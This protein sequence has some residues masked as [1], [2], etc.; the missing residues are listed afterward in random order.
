M[1]NYEGMA[2][3]CVVYKQRDNVLSSFS[4]NSEIILCMFS[5]CYAQSTLTFL[6][7]FFRYARASVR[8]GSYAPELTCC[9][10]TYY[11]AERYRCEKLISTT[12]SF[13]LAN[14]TAVAKT[15]EFL[16][17]SSKE[18]IKW[19]SSEQIVINAEEDVF[20]IILIWINGDKLERKKYFPQLFRQVRL[21]HVSPDYLCSH[22]MTNCFVRDD[23][24]CLNL[25]KGTL[26]VI[27]G[28][29]NYTF[30]FKPRK[31]PHTPVV[32]T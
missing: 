32:V 22:I 4:V 20:K 8:T 31:S 15:G 27:D 25:V 9:I 6:R 28:K 23:K 5:F 24:F 17:M 29:V 3:Y 7:H 30:S 21:P 16:N 10:S 13:M 26:K 14:F 12:R 19:I 1:C 18:L 11:F 2:S